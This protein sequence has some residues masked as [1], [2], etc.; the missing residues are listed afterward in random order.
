MKALVGTFNQEKALVGLLVGAFS[1]IV[2]TGCETDGSLHST[3]PGCTRTA[4]RRGESR[5]PG[6]GMDTM[7]ATREWSSMSTVIRLLTVDLLIV[8]N[9]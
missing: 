1:V 9:D 7:V 4:T 8:I 6:C 2:K 3:T 5:G